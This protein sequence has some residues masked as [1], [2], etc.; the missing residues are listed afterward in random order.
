[1]KAQV[2]LTLVLILLITPSYAQYTVYSPYLNDPEL[3]IGYVDSCANFWLN[4]YDDNLG[5][6]FTNID[7]Y[8]NV[9][10]SW[11]TYK[12]MISQS[13][14][15]YGFVRAYMLTGN[16]LY[17]EMANEAMNF[18]YEHAW[19]QTYGGWYSE[20]DINGNPTHPTWD[21]SM[22][23]QHYALLGISAL[24]EATLD[25]TAWDW[26]MTG[27]YH[28]ESHYW[29]DRIG[30]E[31]YYDYTSANG[32][33]PQ[34]KS[35]N[36]TVDAITTHILS[37]YLLTGDEVY[38]NR[39]RELADQIMVHLEGSMPSQAIGFVEKFDSDWNWN[40]GETMT[41]MG[42]VLKSAWCLGRINQVDPHIEYVESAETLAMDVWNNGYDHDYGGP[43]KDFN[44]ITGQMLLWG[45][46]DSAKAWWQMEQAITAGLELFDIT[47]DSIYLQ[48]ADET[49]DFFMEFFVDHEYGDVYS[50][51]TRYGGQAWGLEKGS[52]GK[53]GYHSI[54]T[55]YYIY[56]YGNLFYKNEPV[57]L[58][59]NFI[60][61]VE[62]RS[63]YLCPIAI[64]DDRLT[65][66]EV[67]WEGEEYT[68]FLAQEKVLNLPAG[69]SGHFEVTFA[70]S[71]TSIFANNIMEL[72]E[73]AVLYPA[74]PNPFNPAAILRFSVN[75]KSDVSLTIY[76]VTGAEVIRLVDGYRDA[77]EYNVGFNG[78][79]LSSGIYLAVLRAGE[80]ISTQKLLLIK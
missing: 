54:E 31:G 80:S 73:S 8:G 67:Y 17:L 4:A 37:L 62:D 53:A 44:R 26:L 49:T 65:I 32:T 41:I 7:R 34:D 18:Q 51:R 68:D 3:A 64:A 9:I 61:S 29:D 47:G 30:L 11:G 43:Y 59:Y 35:F 39:L 28:N 23:D 19:D 79:S 72:P 21:K 36:A 55:G 5:G 56:L 70:P 6:F 16:D 57:T 76:N 14:D 1:M 63:V 66:Q 69:T 2:K 20:L 15:G 58:H 71:Q 74:Y 40:N 78:E 42:H 12:N 75:K 52:G 45:L 27:Y 22:F 48:M 33:N 46:Q 24:Y 60:E 25:T 13:R 38:L 77:G 50:D 10:T